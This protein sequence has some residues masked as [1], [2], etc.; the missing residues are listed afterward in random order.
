[1]SD[2]AARFA[3]EAP[4][5]RAAE[6]RSEGPLLHRYA[7]RLDGLSEPVR[8]L[9]LAPTVSE[10]A[11]ESAF[12]RTVEQWD[13]LDDHPGVVTVHARGTT[14]QPWVAVAA[15][16][17]PLFETEPPLPVEAVRTVAG[18]AAEAL[19]HAASAEV[20]HGALAPEL[21]RVVSADD[22]LR[23]LI[24]WP[25]ERSLRVASGD[26]PV[27]PYTP[28]EHLDEPT[29]ATE[30]TDVYGLGA[31]TYYAL[32]GQV[33]VATGQH[34]NAPSE[35]ETG[36]PPETTADAAEEAT[37]ATG[38][39]PTREPSE[40]TEPTGATGPRTEPATRESTEPTTTAAAIRAGE[41]LPPSV[42]AGVRAAFDDVL[43]RA[44]AP[45]PLDRYASCYAF[46]RAVMF[47]TQARPEP[48]GSNAGA[49]GS[50]RPGTAD[51]DG[52][53]PDQ[54]GD[55]DVGPPAQSDD[56]PVPVGRVER[57][58]SLLTR[59]A[60]LAALGVGALGVAAGGAWVASETLG[61]T[62]GVDGVS[63]FRYDAANTGHAPDTSGPTA[64]ITE[65]WSFGTGGEVPSSPTVAH[66]TVYVGSQDG[67]VYAVDASDG[68][69]QWSVE[70]G[71]QVVLSPAVVEDAV[72]LLTRNDPG[73]TLS[74]LAPGDGSAQW[75]VARPNLARV[76]PAVSDGR[77]YMGGA[78]VIYAFEASDGTEVWAQEGYNLSS[79]SPAVA[80]GMVFFGGRT[81]FDGTADT[82]V[83]GVLALDASDGT[84]QWTFETETFLASSPAVVDGTVYAGGDQV[85]ALDASDGSVQWSV[86]TGESVF[87]SPAVTDD[88][89][90]VG[91]H[92]D[93]VYALDRSTGEER[94]SF[95]TRG[96]VISS[97]A[98]VGVTSV[99][100]GPVGSEGGGTVY[101]GSS[102]GHLYALDAS[103][104]EERWSFET[105]G[106]VISSPAVV[107]GTVYVG[108][109]DGHLYALT[110]P[111]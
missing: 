9:V 11:L 87:S 4:G 32:T 13:S 14:P 106:E 23:A 102:D 45:D 20:T 75:S 51:V 109:N 78:N 50:A 58:E 44:L 33:P 84:E 26:R 69:E 22:G 28:P 21:V 48:T 34:S 86:E 63:M 100:G 71:D 42:A 5:V 47:E 18:D 82:P 68:T 60:T 7:G 56:E 90:Y 76:C 97:P 93:T 17:T 25:L 54:R 103:T 2:P 110:E 99:T 96:D 64:G 83:N 57:E 59:R 66:G 29:A 70:S 19:R 73:R 92:D 1:M 6:R 89:V 41:R 61:G 98:A 65:A 30:R 107:D 12:E 105:D 8:L 40:A 35:S 94:W 72:Y 49:V 91:S 43:A 53:P 111:E 36:N 31:V 101:V 37:D 95:Q 74:A 46:K 77:I 85:Y 10:P 24:D 55:A 38:E 79:L 52:A 81:D 67:F 62:S 15:D 16:G 3:R 108:S 104:G 39:P 27:S 80:D 88:T